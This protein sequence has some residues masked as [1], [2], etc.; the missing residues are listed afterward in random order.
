MVFQ[1]KDGSSKRRTQD[2][3]DH[4]R[5]ERIQMLDGSHR[6]G[7]EANGG[8]PPLKKANSTPTLRRA[9]ASAGADLG[10]CARAAGDGYARS[11]RCTDV[12]PHAGP[13]RRRERK[14]M[15]G[16]LGPA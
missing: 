8:R 7:G 6:F 14:G 12:D 9:R 13:G 5:R 4:R 3:S 16:G 11:R 2:V 10:C 15:G 1:R